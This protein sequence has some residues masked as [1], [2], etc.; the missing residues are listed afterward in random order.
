[1]FSIFNNYFNKY[2]NVIYTFEGKA[3][4]SCHTILQKIILIR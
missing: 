1:M 4:I 2:S 3:E